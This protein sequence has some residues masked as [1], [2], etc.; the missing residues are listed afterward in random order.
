MVAR[1]PHPARAPGWEAQAGRGP[2]PRGDP[3]FE[4]GSPKSQVSWTACWRG[5]PLPLAALGWTEVSVT[6]RDCAV[7]CGPLSSPHTCLW[8]S[9]PSGFSAEVDCWP[10]A[11]CPR[12]RQLPPL[13]PETQTPPFTL[14]SSACPAQ[15]HAH[16]L[17][18]L[19]PLL[20]RL[21]RSGPAVT[22]THLLPLTVAAPC[23]FPICRRPL[24]GTVFCP[25]VQESLL[26]H[27]QRHLTP[28]QTL[29]ESVLTP[30][31]SVSRPGRPLASARPH[32]RLVLRPVLPAGSGLPCRTDPGAPPGL[33]GIRCLILE[34]FPHFQQAPPPEASP[35]LPDLV[36][37]PSWSLLPSPC[38]PIAARLPALR[39]S[40]APSCRGR[41]CVGA[42]CCVRLAAPASDPEAGACFAV[43]SP[44]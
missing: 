19:N 24:R 21:L 22:V 23:S 2:G 5:R 25:A 39:E 44:R 36:G 42:Q 30:R 26:R 9:F 7:R 3:Q 12:L 27:R 17:C 35:S 43:Q 8:P 34:A 1:T 6:E 40:P 14:P 4:E 13:P 28:L 11:R 37:H 15:P 18:L 31:S 38:C 33:C 20:V 29:H 10:W 41:P 16:P 32:L